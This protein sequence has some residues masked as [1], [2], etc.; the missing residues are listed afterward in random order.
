MKLQ[1]ISLTVSLIHLA[2]FAVGLIFLPEVIAVHFDVTLTADFMASKWWLLPAAALPAVIAASS[3]LDKRNR[4]RNG[5]AFGIM[6]FSIVMLLI[7]LGW[8]FFFLGASVEGLG[9]RVSVSIGLLVGMPM[10]FLMLAI[11]NFLP[12]VRQNSLLG[13]RS[14]STLRSEYVWNRTHAL[15][16][17]IMAVCGLVTVAVSVAAA[18]VGIDWIAL[19]VLFVSILVFTLVPLAYGHRLYRRRRAQGLEPDKES[20]EG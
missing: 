15:A 6:I 7:Y 17:L 19:A 11:G 8:L 9:E 20:M 1:K 13:F 5:K 12:T 18:A 16:G 2:A 10:G 3:F 4:E 14:Y